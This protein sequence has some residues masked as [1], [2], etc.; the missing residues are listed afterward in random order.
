MWFK[1][2]VLPGMTGPDV[3]VIRRKFGLVPDGPYDRTTQEL[4][5][6]MARKR[7]VETDG[8]VNEDVA[9][10]LGPAADENE[11]PDWYERDLQQ[12]DAGED[13]RKLNSIFG[14]NDDRFREDTEAAI[15]R[16]Q[17]SLGFDPHGKVDLDLARRIGNHR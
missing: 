9:K 13:V 15:K 3:R 14:I 7:K 12:F 10:E 5:R 17:S 6:G 8:E 4:V 1:R 16:L 2:V 11:A